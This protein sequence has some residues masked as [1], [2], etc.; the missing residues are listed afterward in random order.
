MAIGN[1]S[2]MQAH[3]ISSAYCEYF[4]KYRQSKKSINDADDFVYSYRLMYTIIP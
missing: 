4:H 3:E 1:E 2:K